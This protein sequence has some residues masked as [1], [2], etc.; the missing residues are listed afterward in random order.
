MKKIIIFDFNEDGDREDY[1]EIEKN[2]DAGWL[3][4]EILNMM[5]QYHK[6][7]LYTN[8]LEEDEF[9]ELNKKEQKL[10][11]EVVDGLCWKILDMTNESNWTN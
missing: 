9:D 5:R 1:L 4:N 2:R 10:V 11:S 3:L 6:H 8:L 7:G